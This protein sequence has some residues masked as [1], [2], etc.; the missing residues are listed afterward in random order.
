MDKV[1]PRHVV[2]STDKFKRIIRK[3]SDKGIEKYGQPLK[4]IATEYD[5][6][7]MAEEEMV[8]GFQYLVAEQEKRK[9]VVEKIRRLVNDS[10]DF[11]KNI[12]DEVNYWLDV[13][14]GK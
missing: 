5:W 7:Q 6:L 13:L 10:G 8:D 14:E 4:P 2:L 12:E 11:I 9:F 1:L 3:Q